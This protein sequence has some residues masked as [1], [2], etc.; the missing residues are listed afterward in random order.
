MTHAKT[1]PEAGLDL[2]F[3]DAHTAHGWADE[4]VSDELLAKIYDDAKWGP[5]SA[6]TSPMRIVFLRSQAA[7]ERLKPH[8][9]EGNVAKVMTSPVTAIFAYDTRFYEHLPTLFPHVN[10]R[11]WFEGNQALIDSTAFRN[12]TLQGA[13]FLIAA[14]AHGL[15][16]GPMSGFNNAG[17]DKEFFPDGRCKSNFICALG[18]G[19]AAKFFPRNP[20]FKFEEACQVL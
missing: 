6:N 19:H 13:Y 5:T 9:M 3:R 20:R 7:K 12:G 17:V 16:C 14:R 8:L 11:A 18:Y 15:D 10:A 1:L 2:I 4:P